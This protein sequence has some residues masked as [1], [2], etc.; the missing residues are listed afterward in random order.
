MFNRKKIEA[1]TSVPASPTMNIGCC[2]PIKSTFGAERRSPQEIYFE[3]RGKCCKK[4][5]SYNG[6]PNKVKLNIGQG[7]GLKQINNEWIYETNIDFL[8]RLILKW[9]G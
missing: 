1:P 2:A 7:P 3:S 4:L 9:F 5:L 6:Y 8:F